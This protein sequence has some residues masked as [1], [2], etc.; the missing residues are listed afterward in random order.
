VKTYTLII[1]VLLATA[2]CLGG[3]GY[4]E[5]RTNPPITIPPTEAPPTP[6]PTEIPMSTFAPELPPATPEPT[7][8]PTAPP[9]QP[10]PPPPPSPPDTPP[11]ETPP[12]TEPPTPEP[13]KLPYTLLW[14]DNIGT[15][16]NGVD[17]TDDGEKIL[18]GASDLYAYTKTGEILWQYNLQGSLGDVSLTPT[19]DRIIASSFLSPNGTIYLLGGNGRR[20]WEK[21]LEDAAWGVDIS[22]DGKIIAL[23]MGN[24]KIRKIDMNGN[25]QWD[26][27]TRHSAWGVWEVGLKPDGG[28]VGGS[29]DTYFYILNPEGGLIFEDTHGGTGH[30]TGVAVSREGDYVGLVTGRSMSVY[31][32]QGTTL[33]WETTTAFNNLDIDMTPDGGLIAVA[34]Y[35]KNVYL[36]NTQGEIVMKVPLKERVQSVAL[37]SDGKYLVAGTWNGGVYLFEVTP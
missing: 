24:N 15:D 28:V 4:P 29:D 35:D 18:A 13:V 2:G 37:S 27:D 31:F 36:F 22:S 6:L 32:Y 26:Y 33:L 11:P 12:P 14:E 17:I 3:P 1:L 30:T 20:I 23:S 5:R 16:V 9:T 7:P 34:S 10:P 8:A 21:T 19:G 25:T